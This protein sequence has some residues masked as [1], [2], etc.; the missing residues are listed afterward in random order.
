MAVRLKR[1]EPVGCK[2]YGATAGGQHPRDFGGGQPVVV[3]MF[4]H[5]MAE[6]QVEVIVGIGQGFAGCQ[7]QLRAGNSLRRN[8]EV[9]PLDIDARHRARMGQQRPHIHPH[10]AAIHQHAP[11]FAAH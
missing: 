11:Q 1:V 9:L 3:H 6:H 2:D 10:A 8:A 7:L 5:F 4:E